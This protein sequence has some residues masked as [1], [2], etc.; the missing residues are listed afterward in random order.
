MCQTAY[1]WFPTGSA[2]HWS[3]R[4]IALHLFQYSWASNLVRS[5][6]THPQCCSLPL[7]LR[8]PE[9]SFAPPSATVD[10]FHQLW[11]STAARSFLTYPESCSVPLP[12]QPESW[13]LEAA[14]HS[15]AQPESYFP[16]QVWELESY[17]QNQTRIKLGA[18]TGFVPC[19]STKCAW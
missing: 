11:T 19:T 3:G 2:L 16:D 9:C 14:R 17:N 18:E 8:W 15:S 6:S 12:V 1:V 10:F 5:F 7:P 4:N 13:P